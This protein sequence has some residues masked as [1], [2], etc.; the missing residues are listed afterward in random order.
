MGLTCELS[1]AYFIGENREA[2]TLIYEVA[3]AAGSMGYVIQVAG[4]GLPIAFSCIEA[5]TVLEGAEQATAPCMLPGNENPRSVMGPVLAK[6]GLQCTPESARAIGKN[7][8]NTYI[9]VQCQGGTGYIVTTSNPFDATGEV[10]AQNCLRYDEGPS[11]VRCTLVDTSVRLAVVDRYAQQAA[12]G[13]VVTDR[14]FVGVFQGGSTYFESSCEDGKGY[15][16]KIDTSGEL[17]ETI[18]C[19]RAASMLEGGCKLTDAR[20]ALTEQAQLYTV[21]ANAAGSDCNVE[22]YALFP[23]RTPEQEAV[24]LVCRD[25]SGAIGVFYRGGAGDR[26]FSCGHGPLAGFACSLTTDR[27][28]DYLT[29]DLIDLNLNDCVVSD[30]SVLGQNPSGRMLMEVACTD[31]FK[32]YVI[33]YELEPELKCVEAVNCVT[34]GICKLPGNI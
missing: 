24:E 34:A 15:V 22:R 4:D 12:N 23:T 16:Y 21:L 30:S 29:E 9:E 20:E 14:R 10:T 31:G 28:Y 8:S 1:D 26:V 32:G 3:C 2:Q 33:E 6:I 18:D 7:P 17:L 11:N 25:G 27:G 13:C 5:N 19:V